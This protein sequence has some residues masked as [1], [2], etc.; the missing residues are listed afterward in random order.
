MIDSVYI[1]SQVLTN[2]FS[3]CVKGGKSPDILKYADILPVFK[4]GDTTDKT[5]YRPLIT[6]SIFQK[7]L[8]K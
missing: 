7:F 4:K 8:I 2:I 5:N 1:Y 6:L 3:N